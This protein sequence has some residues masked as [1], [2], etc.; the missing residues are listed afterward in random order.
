MPAHGAIRAHERRQGLP[1]TPVISLSAHAQTEDARASLEAGC[2]EHLTKPIGQARLLAAIARWATQA[3]P[4]GARPATEPTDER[5]PSAAPV[6]PD[7]MRRRAHARLFLGRWDSN[8]RAQG[9]DRAAQRRL[10]TDLQD[11]AEG[12]QEPELLT[13]ARQL[14]QDPRHPSAQQAVGA[15]VA[16][17]LRRLKK[18][19]Q[20][21]GDP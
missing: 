17:V 8:W 10:A 7:L 13:A 9:G 16:D 2:D 20:D 6:S 15:A 1:R 21:P 18:A 14:A 12:L 4:A 3:E 5:T 11:C 19:E